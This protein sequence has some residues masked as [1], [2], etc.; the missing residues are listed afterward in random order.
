MAT[1]GQRMSDAL[2]ISL[3]R[4]VPPPSN[5]PWMSLFTRQNAHVVPSRLGPTIFAFCSSCLP[6]LLLFS[7]ICLFGASQSANNIH[8]GKMHLHAASFICCIAS[9][10]ALQSPHAKA[11]DRAQRQRRTAQGPSDYS[12][13][14]P[15]FTFED[16]PERFPYLK[17]ETESMHIAWPLLGTSN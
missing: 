7:S 10:I 2:S 17:P 9:V 3:S 15:S 16:N 13:P 1:A 5:E 11:H 6:A 8:S 4:K 12:K 14:R